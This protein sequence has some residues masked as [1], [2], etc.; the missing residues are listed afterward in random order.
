MKKTD[1]SFLF[2]CLFIVFGVMRLGGQNPAQTQASNP[3][4]EPN[5]G[6]ATAVKS[7]DLQRV[8]IS[9][10]PEIRI[11][12]TVTDEGG[13]SVTGLTEEELEVT[14]DDV[15][16][17]LS[18][19]TSAFE[20][21]TFLAVALLFDRSG[22]MKNAIDRTREAGMAFLQRMSADD[23]IAVF[24]FDHLVRMDSGFTEDRSVSRQ[25]IEAIALGG[26]TALYDA[27]HDAVEAFL[28]VQTP[29][30]AIVVLSDGKDTKSQ[31]EREAV[32]AKVI[33]AGIPVFAVNLDTAGDANNLKDV[34]VQ[35]GG[36]YFEAASPSEL[37][38]LYRMI[39]DQ[40]NNQ[41]VAA[42]TSSS[43]LDEQFH[44]L[45]ITF[46]DPR[47]ESV[48]AAKEYVATKGPGVPLE[49]VSGFEREL[50]QQSLIPF[51]GL[52]L[53]F[54]LMLG[55]VLLLLMRLIRPD[56]RILSLAGIGLL[57]MCLLLG[58]IVGA[59]LFY[60]V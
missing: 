22:S 57:L 15:I 11:F 20:G 44:G 55:M 46:K 3:D 56:I 26:D 58:G 37:L 5:P 7:V 19:L 12:F 29:R 17:P 25:A 14:I 48:S 45:K 50:E 4:Q 35:T 40:L 10:L 9:S 38:S 8:D 39:A 13:E 24:T 33:G 51:I 60:G 53:L 47:G 49:T 59:I 43:G 31:M 28:S 32:L 27:L 6:P 1:V 34:C 16:Q 30:Q 18:S 54:G 21:G 2:L 42:F 23:R 52:G 36:R 41:Y